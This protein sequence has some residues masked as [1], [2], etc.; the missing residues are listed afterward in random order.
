MTLAKDLFLL[1]NNQKNQNNQYNQKKKLC[2]GY[3][4]GAYLYLHKTISER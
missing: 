2:Y 1:Q 3:C 4:Y